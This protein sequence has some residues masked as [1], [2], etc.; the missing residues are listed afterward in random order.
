VGVDWGSELGCPRRG[1]PGACRRRRVHAR[2]RQLGGEGEGTAS[3]WGRGWYGKARHEANQTS[4]AGGWRIWGGELVSRRSTASSVGGVGGRCPRL[5][6][7]GGSGWP[8][9]AGCTAR[10]VREGQGGTVVAGGFYSRSGGVRRRRG[11]TV[12]YPNGGAA[13]CPSGGAARRRGAVESEHHVR[14]ARRHMA[15]GPAMLVAARGGR[16]AL[17]QGREREKGGR[18]LGPGGSGRGERVAPAMAAMRRGRA[19]CG[20]ACSARRGRRQGGG[21]D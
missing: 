3:R 5:A 9:V 19:A 2:R 4:E 20:T 17:D 1:G 18:W 13:R 6:A 10:V 14:G 21:R 16:C 7:S 8:V 15:A 12:R 11:G